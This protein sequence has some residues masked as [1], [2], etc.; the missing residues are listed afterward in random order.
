MLDD[1][2]WEEIITLTADDVDNFQDLLENVKTVFYDIG[3]R[4]FM[5][6]VTKPGD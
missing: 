1:G 5:F 6:G 2:A 3:R 4:L